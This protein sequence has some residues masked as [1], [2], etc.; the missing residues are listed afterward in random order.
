MAKKRIRNSSE[1]LL[2]EADS[3]AE[4][5]KIAAPTEI[6]KNVIS[7]FCTLSLRCKKLEEDAKGKLKD[8]KITLKQLRYDVLQSLKSEKSEILMIPSKLR[9]QATAKAATLGLPPIPA[10][11]RLTKNTKDLTITP[12]IIEEAFAAISEEDIMESDGDATEAIVSALLSSVRR[13]VRS[14]NEQAK[15]TDSLPR[16][17]KA[18]DVEIANDMLAEEAIRMHEQSSIVLN[19]EREKRDAVS[20]LKTEIAAKS[21]DVEKYFSRVNATSQKVNLDNSSYNLCCRT[22]VTRPK[23]TLKIL[24]DFIVDGLK[25]CL[26]GG[27]KKKLTKEDLISSLK[28]KREEIQKLVVSKMST[29]AS[30]SKTVVHLQRIAIKEKS[31]E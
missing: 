13:L 4:S 18:A 21:S 10:Y 14:F 15:L 16:G 23:V 11:I 26:H 31:S 25:E 6:E 22:T 9:K 1:G 30:T 20:E 7:I 2:E 27:S 5:Q 24:E 17:V 12:E 29:V 19:T 3:V 28:V 8:I